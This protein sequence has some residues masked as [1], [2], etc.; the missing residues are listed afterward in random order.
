MTIVNP[1]VDRAVTLAVQR[2]GYYYRPA[3]LL[4]RR[5]AVADTLFNQLGQLLTA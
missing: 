1:E 5:K 2:I 4:N 3:V